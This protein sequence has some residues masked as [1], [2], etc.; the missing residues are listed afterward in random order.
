MHGNNIPQDPLFEKIIGDLSSPAEALEYEIRSF[1]K[2][3]KQ[4]FSGTHQ[5]IAQR[6][7]LPF[8]S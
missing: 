4:R 2:K 5:T 7:S 1:T 3:R 8:E 6:W